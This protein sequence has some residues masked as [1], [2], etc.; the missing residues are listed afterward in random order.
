MTT[1]L[2]SEFAGIFRKPSRENA[3]KVH[4]VNA[5]VAAALGL[6]LFVVYRSTY[7]PE[8]MTLIDTSVKVTLNPETRSMRVVETRV[9]TGHADET[10]GVLRSVYAPGVSPAQVMLESGLMSAQKGQ[11]VTH[12]ALDLPSGIYGVWCLR[13]A[14]NWWPSWSQRE[15]VMT[16]PDV[17]FFGVQ[18]YENH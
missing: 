8:P 11:F 5:I 7:S 17:C 18:A 15:F 2:T 10:V 9:F 14:Y 16:V 1:D 13:T 4:A 3:T 12:N 6:F